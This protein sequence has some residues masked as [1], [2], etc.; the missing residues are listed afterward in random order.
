[1]NSVPQVVADAA[2][3]SPEIQTKEAM[4]ELQL[5]RRTRI[6][7]I[8]AGM[9]DSEVVQHTEAVLENCGETNLAIARRVAQE[10]N[11]LLGATHGG[12]TDTVVVIL[13]DIVWHCHRLAQQVE[14]NLPATL[15]AVAM[16]KLANAARR[17]G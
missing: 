13:A 10:V 11:H 2:F 16:D 3:Q 7:R 6:E 12:D 17:E 8:G 9:T 1:M 15:R 4:R 14:G 5:G